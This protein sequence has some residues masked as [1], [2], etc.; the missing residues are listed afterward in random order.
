MKASLQYSDFSVESSRQSKVIGKILSP[1]TCPQQF[2]SCG[3]S[4]TQAKIIIEIREE[5]QDWIQLFDRFPHLMLEYIPAEGFHHTSFIKVSSPDKI[6]L[7]EG[8]ELIWNFSGKATARFSRMSKTELHLVG[9][10]I[11]DGSWLVGIKPVIAGI[12]Q[13]VVVEKIDLPLKKDECKPQGNP[14]NQTPSDNNWVE[15]W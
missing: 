12:Q 10:A 9:E 13:A 7:P 2:A 11:P 3:L 14:C 1:F 8:G 4:E 5:Y 6:W 15:Y